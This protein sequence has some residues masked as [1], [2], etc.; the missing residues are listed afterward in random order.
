MDESFLNTLN[1]RFETNAINYYLIECAIQRNRKYEEINSNDFYVMLFMTLLF[2]DYKFV[3]SEYCFFE[4]IESFIRGICKNKNIDINKLTK[5]I[6]RDCFQ[7]KGKPNSFSS[8]FLKNDVPIQLITDKKIEGVNKFSYELSEN[9]NKWLYS[10][11][12]MEIIGHISIENILLEK[13]IVSGNFN[14]AEQRSISLLSAVRKEISNI[15]DY[16]KIILA[17]IDDVKSD[18]IYETLT[19]SINLI[20]RQRK[21]TQKIKELIQK[22]NKKDVADLRIEEEKIK[23][24]LDSIGRTQ[25]NLNDILEKELE[26]LKM[27]IDLRQVF[28][29]SLMDFSFLERSQYININRDILSNIRKYPTDEFPLFDVL[30]PLMPFKIPKLSNPNIVLKEQ[31]IRTKD[32]TLEIE[33]DSFDNLSDEEEY[34]SKEKELEEKCDDIFKCILRDIISSEGKTKLSEFFNAHPEIQTLLKEIKTVLTILTHNEIIYFKDEQ[35]KNNFSLDSFIPENFGLKYP[36]FNLQN[37][38]L[39]SKLSLEKIELKAPADGMFQEVL[40]T[41][42]IYFELKEVDDYE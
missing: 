25:K 22:I 31:V 14:N 18:D 28:S 10:T 32:E 15:E 19:N 39:I 42:E 1:K 38:I 30:R 11:Y 17:G 4:D 21:E 2:I 7:N 16:K 6:V 26:L 35:D 40:K 36:E 27:T 5:D 9:C 12:E 29:D 24:N 23:N 20:E 3:S 13:E 41:D 37:K 34:N 33:L 8:S